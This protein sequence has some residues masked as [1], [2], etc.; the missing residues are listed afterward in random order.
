MVPALARE[1]EPRDRARASL[2]VPGRSRVP[3]TDRSSSNRRTVP[4]PRVGVIWRSGALL[5][6]ST[7]GHALPVRTAAHENGWTTGIAETPD[8]T[9]AAW[10]SRTDESRPIPDCIEDSP[11]NAMR[12][13]DFAL[14]QK[15]GHGP[16]SAAPSQWRARA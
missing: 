8:G 14:R 1:R 4:A 13:A 7:S 5:M 9:F 6:D 12:A 11:E 3:R 10:A 16:C 2:C 15:T